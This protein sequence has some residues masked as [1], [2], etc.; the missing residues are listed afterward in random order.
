[1]E[2]KTTEM[3]P[4]SNISGGFS[5]MNTKTTG[6]IELT[7]GESMVFEKF[8]NTERDCRNTCAMINRV[9]VR[10]VYLRS[11]VSLFN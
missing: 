6:F 11:Q 4:I 10:H 9:S 8:F 5:H 1:M 3:I 2:Y 7:F